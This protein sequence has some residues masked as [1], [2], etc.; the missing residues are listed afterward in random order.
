MCQ[1]KSQEANLLERERE[2]EKKLTSKQKKETK[3]K[4][5]VFIYFE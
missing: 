1:I 2:N 3:K 5:N 4:K